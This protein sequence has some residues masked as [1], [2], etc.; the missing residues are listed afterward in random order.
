ML[1]DPNNNGYAV[2]LGQPGGDYH[3]KMAKAKVAKTVVVVYRDYTDQP[4][5]NAVVK[6]ANS[7]KVI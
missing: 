4:D 7:F 1:C 5:A 6:I 3:I 2:V